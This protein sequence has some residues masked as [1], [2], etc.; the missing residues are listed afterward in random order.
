MVKIKN[1]WWKLETFLAYASL[2]IVLSATT[3]TTTSYLGVFYEWLY[4]FLPDD[5]TLTAISLCVYILITAGT[6]FVTTKL[7]NKA[8]GAIFQRDFY[9]EGCLNL[10]IGYIRDNHDKVIR[11]LA[12]LKDCYTCTACIRFSREALNEAIDYMIRNRV[13][14]RAFR[15]HILP[16]HLG[17]LQPHIELQTAKKLRKIMIQDEI[18][19]LV[20][21]VPYPAFSQLEHEIDI[22]ILDN[23]N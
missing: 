3:F 20:Y 7:I 5:R 14:Y 21:F 2:A 12:P 16:D 11:E 23:C 15:G 8:V 4:P 6:L 18:I 22:A 10:P 9:T 17:F 1:F 13:K 19:T